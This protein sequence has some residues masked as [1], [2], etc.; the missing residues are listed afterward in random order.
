MRWKSDPSRNNDPEASSMATV[1]NQELPR[2]LEHAQKSKITQWITQQCY[3]ESLNA[4]ITISLHARSDNEGLL[5][6]HNK[7][8]LRNNWI[9]SSTERLMSSSKTHVE[10][11]RLWEAVQNDTW[12]HPEEKWSHPWF[13]HTHIPMNSQPSKDSPTM[14]CRRVKWGFQHDTCF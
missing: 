12:K 13:T 1:E 10:W 9:R 3:V 5:Q 2:Q 4:S 7:E 14:I 6:I 8:M 11:S